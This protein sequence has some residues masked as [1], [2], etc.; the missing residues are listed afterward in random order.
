LTKILNRIA[1]RKLST[2]MM[3]NSVNG[4]SVLKKVAWTA[5]GDSVQE[6][7]EIQ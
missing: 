7:I 2:M 6:A 4:N 3:K 5:Y 1:Q